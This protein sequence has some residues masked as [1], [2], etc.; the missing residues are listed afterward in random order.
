MNK[1]L[2]FLI[3]GSFFKTLRFNFHYFGFKGLFV[4]RVMI[5]RGTKFGKLKGT[6]ECPDR[7]A[8]SNIGFFRNS[9]F[10]QV[11]GKTYFSNEGKLI[12][13][14]HLA[15]AYGASLLIRKNADVDVGNCFIG[16]FAMIDISNH[17][18]IGRKCKLSW[19]IQVIDHDSHKIV[20]V[21]TMKNINPGAP[22]VLEDD[23]W[24]CSN[25][26]VL[27]GCHL[28]KGSILASGSF[29][30]K[31]IRQTNVIVAGNKIVKENVLSLDEFA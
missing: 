15:L 21:R 19:M 23:V 17:L 7:I 29:C 9:G 5:A 18:S 3:H 14:E 8:C 16:Q 22:I 12:I 6:V 10:P 1:V 24:I 20:D 4:P 2:K 27:K 30:S 28:E 31:H 11:K 26:L 25:A 13:R